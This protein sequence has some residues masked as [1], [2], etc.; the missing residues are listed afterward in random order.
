MPDAIVN[1]CEYGQTIDSIREVPW[2]FP[3]VAHIHGLTSRSCRSLPDCRRS[4]RLLENLMAGNL[5]AL[6]DDAQAP[7]HLPPRLVVCAR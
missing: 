1:S 5:P 6:R 2:E 7:F 3:S 4:A